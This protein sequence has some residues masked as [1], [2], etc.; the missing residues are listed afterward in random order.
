MAALLYLPDAAKDAKTIISLFFKVAEPLL[1]A[2]TIP[3]PVSGQNKAGEENMV[4]LFRANTY[5]NS[6]R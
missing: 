4:F 3:S 2:E 6:L 5:K 1:V